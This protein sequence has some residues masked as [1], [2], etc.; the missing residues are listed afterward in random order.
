MGLCVKQ[1]CLVMNLYFAERLKNKSLIPILVIFFIILT[2]GLYLFFH[3]QANQIRQNKYAEIRAIAELKSNEIIR[4]LEERFLDADYFAGSPELKSVIR[5][6]NEG[7]NVEIS[8]QM[9]FERVFF[10]MKRNHRYEDIL[11]TN[12]AGKILYSFDSRHAN[13]DSSTMAAIFSVLESGKII[14]NDFYFS[15]SYKK[16]LLDIVAPVDLKDG[17]IAALVFT[18]DPSVFLY[19]QIRFWPTPSKSSETLLIRKD[20][21]SVAYLNPLR[22]MHNFPLRLKLTV[23]DLNLTAARAVSGY[24][25]IF[26]GHDYRG[27]KVIGDIRPVPGTP[28]FM[29]AKIDKREVY[30]DLRFRLVLLSFTVLLF[31]LSIAFLVA[32]LYNRRLNAELERRVDDRTE[33]LKRIN[34]ELESFA[35][36]VSHDLRAPLR[37]IDGFSAI[38]SK[39]YTKYLDEEGLRFIAVIRQNAQKMGSLIDDLLSFSRLGRAQ[40]LS[41]SLSMKDMAGSVFEELYLT[42]IHHKID[43]RLSD[44][45]PARGDADMIRQ[46]WVNLISNAIKF[47]SRNE[48]AEIN[49]YSRVEDDTLVY[50]IADN[51]A[52]FDM[53]YYNKLFGVFQR[54]HSEREFEGTGVGLAIVQQVISRHGGRVWAE[55]KMNQGATFYFSLPK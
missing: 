16:N 30:G 4:W 26:S 11:V 8:D 45:H 2:I 44:L 39:D 55:G 27:V 40:M 37:A 34:K 36:S 50:C 3:H 54:L 23:S 25:G 52:G 10:R 48:N 46:V 32:Y 7:D 21:D 13:P 43:F 33:Q 24:S 19:P 31:L 35:Y 47:T 14:M 20:N 15:R 29:V 6:V 38:L 41:T 42:G 22:H 28:W 18:I 12:S 5:R 49:I 1:L 17:N 53:K 51:G 9:D